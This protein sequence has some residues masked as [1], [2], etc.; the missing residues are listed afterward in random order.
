MNDCL[1][2]WINQCEGEECNCEEYLS[3]NSPQGRK[4]ADKYDE[5]VYEVAKKIGKELMDEFKN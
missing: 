5:R 1:W 2:N 3:V 4:I